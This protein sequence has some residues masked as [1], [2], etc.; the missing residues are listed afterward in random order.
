[1]K[2]SLKFSLNFANTEKLK[3]LEE[4]AREYRRA[5]NYYLSILAFQA[6]YDLSE[7]EIKLFV[8]P[9]SYRYKQC[10]SRQAVKIWK[11]WRRNKKRGEL[12]LFKGA[13]VLDERFIK[14]EK[15]RDTTFDWW[16]K[17]AT[18]DKGHPVLIPIRSY[19]YANDYFDNWKVVNGGRLQDKDGEWFLILTFGKEAPEKRE[20]GKVLGV[21]IGYRKL[22]TT[23]EREFLGKD[24][25]RL[26]EK[27]ARRKQKS[28]NW[29]KTGVE[30][31]NYVGRIA[32]ELF[33]KP[34]KVIVL[35]DLKELRKDKS[36]E[37]SKEVN[38]RFNFWLYGLLIKRIKELGEQFGV[39]VVLVPPAYTSQT[40]PICYHLEKANRNGESFKCL[41]CGFREDADYVG[42]LNILHRFAEEPIVPQ[43][44]ISGIYEPI[45]PQIS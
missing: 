17:I 36:G 12:P 1:M 20:E 18:L 44:S 39:Q 22:I 34:W 41:R 10:A 13:L 32:K 24:I 28:R 30:I 9:L 25:K 15:A 14:V 23:S 42:A 8:S 40:C 43:V 29:I 26:T 35:E 27:S 16:V 2:R 19:E 7:E 3:R 31:R 38:R 37:W 33:N 6:K 21:D 45:C 5:V 4:L 11:T